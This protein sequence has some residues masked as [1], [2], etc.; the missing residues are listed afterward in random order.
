[1]QVIWRDLQALWDHIISL[2]N[3]ITNV[4]FLL[5]WCLACALANALPRKQFLQAKKLF[6]SLKVIKPLKSYVEFS[7]IRKC[8]AVCL[9]VKKVIFII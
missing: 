9:L 2:K 1:M 4:H 7:I 5:A 8:L 6:A 3:K